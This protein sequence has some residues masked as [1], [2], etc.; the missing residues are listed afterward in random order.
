MAYQSTQN[1]PLKK[2]EAVAGDADNIRDDIRALR[3]DVTTLISDASDVAKA[4]ARK[5]IEKG[6]EAAA[7]AQDKLEDSLATV[8]QRVRQNP[9][10]AI[11]IAFGVGV[12]LS[13]LTR[14]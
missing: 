10:T 11:G 6:K 13:A 3:D 14:R 1:D 7:E 9:L 2:T 5:G 8:E 12:L 4:G